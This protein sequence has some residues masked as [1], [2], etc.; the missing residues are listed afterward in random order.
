MP[1][2]L[3]V[4]K[5]GI[6]V[7]L[8][9]VRAAVFDTD[10]FW[11][12]LGALPARDERRHLAGALLGMPLILPAAI[13]VGQIQSDPPL[14]AVGQI[15]P[16]APSSPMGAALAQ[17]VFSPQLWGL[18]PGLSATTTSL[19]A[20]YGS[21]VASTLATAALLWLFAR[22]SGIRRDWSASLRVAAWG[23][24]PFWLSCAGL[25]QLSLLPLVAIGLMHSCHV[26]HSGVCRRLGASSPD[27]A[28]LLGIVAVALLVLAP[29][30]AY[31][32]S[33]LA[34]FVFRLAD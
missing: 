14:A 1:S 23:G 16:L 30:A 11:P 33:A 9:L 13:A 29:L 34:G 25:L 10:R 26:A 4:A 22:V 17:S 8:G 5:R 18:S 24:L 27:G 2:D 28:A 15:S 32:A 7:F 6:F 3:P 20:A 21:A 19:L 12:M 31:L